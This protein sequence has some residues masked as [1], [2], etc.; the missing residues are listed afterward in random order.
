MLLLNRLIRPGILLL[1]RLIR[2]GILPSGSP[3]RLRILP[4][5]SPSLLPVLSPELRKS[6]HP[7]ENRRWIC[8]MCEA[9]FLRKSP[10]FSGNKIR[11]TSP[12]RLPSDRKKARHT[13]DFLSVS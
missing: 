2:P 3:A 11:K 7:Q 4:P 1:N 8:P 9:S 10:K 5:D 13:A 12:D 6:P